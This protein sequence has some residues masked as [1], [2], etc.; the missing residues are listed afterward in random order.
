MRGG[1]V[2]LK[3]SLHLSTRRSLANNRCWGKVESSAPHAQHLYTLSRLNE[4]CGR[5]WGGSFYC[6]RSLVAQLATFSAG[7]VQ[8]C[9][10]HPKAPQP[11]SHL[12]RER[13]HTQ[14][15]F[16]LERRRTVDPTKSPT[17]AVVNVENEKNLPR[18]CKFT[19]HECHEVEQSSIALLRGTFRPTEDFVGLEEPP[20]PLP[21]FAHADIAVRPK[22]C[23]E[24]LWLPVQVKSTKCESRPTKNRSPSWKFRRVR[25]YDGMVVAFVSLQKDC[26]LGP[27][28]WLFPGRYFDSL[29]GEGSFRITQGGKHD[30]V[31]SRFRFENHCVLHHDRH[32]GQALYEKWWEARKDRGSVCDPYRLQSFSSLQSQLS[33][34]HLKEW[35]ML[36]RCLKLFDSVPGGVE[37]RAAL[38]PSLPHDIEIRL[39]SS[40][41]NEWHRV[42][43]KSSCWL[44]SHRFAA[45]NMS[46][47]LGSHTLPY[48]EGDFDFLLVSS[49]QNG[50]SSKAFPP[51]FINPHPPL[52]PDSTSFFLIPMSELVKEGVVYSEK[53]KQRGV[54][55]LGLDFSIDD[56]TYTC[57]PIREPPW[58]SQKDGDLAPFSSQG[59]GENGATASASN[60]KSTTACRRSDHFDFPNV[61]GALYPDFFYNNAQQQPYKEAATK[62]RERTSF[63]EAV[64]IDHLPLHEWGRTDRGALLLLRHSLAPEPSSGFAGLEEPPIPLSPY[65]TDHVAVRPIGCAEDLWLPVQLRSTRTQ[66]G[67]RVTEEG[68]GVRNPSWIFRDLSR[69]GTSALCIFVQE[70][71]RAW[72]FPGD[73]LPYSL[74]NSTSRSFRITEGGKYD[75]EGRRCSFQH[76]FPEG[77]H[78]GEALL[79]IWQE[80]RD[81]KRECELLPLNRLSDKLNPLPKHRAQR[82][83]KWKVNAW[84][85]LTAG[86]QVQR[87]LSSGVSRRMTTLS[88][89]LRHY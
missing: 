74:Q 18:V 35:E 72:L 45:V 67:K 2:L 61:Q 40:D 86:Q 25:G 89:Y 27:K 30:N 59:I 84:E 63:N 79:T 37:V 8:Q 62:Y 60:R 80:C 4:S 17:D 24:D 39:A 20:I 78:V 3:G 13:L 19:S 55:G 47:R 22:G 66:F 71:P 56:S 36:Q 87:I 43:L 83:V 52:D 85:A 70:F 34:A 50:K 31:E 68:G 1:R 41:Q 73:S 14:E 44:P 57:V 15:A 38:Y 7:G 64:D 49:P 82:L 54:T 5:I 69:D 48:A 11:A 26:E 77:R 33:P 51:E 81:G 28:V 23:T 53:E 9:L 21:H 46:R 65:T 88:H 6:H 76:A 12:R 32:V 75:R 29:A 10:T 58:I 42:Q 16:H